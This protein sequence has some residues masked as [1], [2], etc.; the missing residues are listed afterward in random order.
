MAAS[1][2]SEFA[3]IGLGKIGGALARHAV[4]KGYRVV[5]FTR[6][7]VPDELI[8]VGVTAEAATYRAALRSSRPCG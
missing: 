7:G 3:I 8:Y 6:H 4:E 2:P 1:M 5:G